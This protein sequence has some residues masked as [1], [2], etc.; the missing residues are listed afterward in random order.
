MRP[1]YH[2]SIKQDLTGQPCYYI[3]KL[4]WALRELV[5]KRESWISKWSLSKTLA[6]HKFFLMITNVHHRKLCQQFL[7]PLLRPFFTTI[8]HSAA[9][10]F[11]KEAE[12]GHKSHGIS[13]SVHRQGRHQHPQVLASGPSAWKEDMPS[14]T[15]EHSAIVCSELSFKATQAYK[16]LGRLLPGNGIGG[17]N[18]QIACQSF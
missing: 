14:L 3:N 16:T 17:Q 11:N 9:K 7:L 6:Q 13:Q 8:T 12:R 10:Y 18:H 1:R 15:P 4:P 2:A 5:R